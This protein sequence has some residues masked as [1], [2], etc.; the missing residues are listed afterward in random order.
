MITFELVATC[1]LTVL[2][3]NVLHSPIAFMPMLF[4]L[5]DGAVVD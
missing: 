4:C 3:L 2:E 5:D 1:M